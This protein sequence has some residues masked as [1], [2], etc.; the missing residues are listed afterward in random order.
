MGLAVGALQN[1]LRLPLMPLTAAGQAT[2]GSALRGPKPDL[3]I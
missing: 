2:V 3:T 1:T